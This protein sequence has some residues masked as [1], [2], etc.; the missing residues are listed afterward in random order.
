MVIKGKARGG[1]SALAAH[2]QR[3]DTNEEIRLR[4]FEGVT[5]KPFQAPA[6]YK[7]TELPIAT[8]EDWRRWATVGGKKIKP[9]K[10]E[11]VKIEPPKKERVRIK[12]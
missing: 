12:S 11:R 8:A 9:T 2:L 4:E 3:L 7:M 5:S 10:R 6:K 1:A